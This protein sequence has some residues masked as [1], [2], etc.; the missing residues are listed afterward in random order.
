ML[1]RLGS[2][3]AL[4]GGLADPPG[5]VRVLLLHLPELQAEPYV[6]A[7]RRGGN[8]AGRPV[9]VAE[10]RRLAEEVAGTQRADLLVIDEDVGSAGLDDEEAVAAFP[11]SSTCAG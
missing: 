2:G 8:H 5:Q 6:Q 3:R 4:H 7:H 1:S 10:D 11:E 9:P